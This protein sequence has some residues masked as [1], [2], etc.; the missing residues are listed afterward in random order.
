M[1]NKIKGG[2]YVIYKHSPRSFMVA[3]VLT[4]ETYKDGFIRILVN[5]EVT[6][7]SVNLY[8]GNALTRVIGYN[9]SNAWYPSDDMLNGIKRITKKDFNAILKSHKAYMDALSKADEAFKMVYDGVN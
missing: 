9:R 1:S 7:D 8:N 4:I 2:D 3:Q 5:N 6:I